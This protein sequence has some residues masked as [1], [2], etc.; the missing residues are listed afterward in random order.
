M[1]IGKVMLLGVGFGDFDFFMLKVVKVL[2]VVDVLLFDDF[3]VFGIV[4]F[5]LQ[6]CVICVGKCGGC[7]FMLQVFIEKL[8]CCYVLCGVYVVCVK[9]GDVL[10]FGC[11]GEEFVM[12]CVVVI[13]VEIVNGILLGFVVVVSFGILFMYCEYCQGVM[14]V[15]VYCQDYGEFDWVWF[16][17]IGIMFVIYMGMSCVDSIVVG[18]F[19]VFF[20]LMLVVVV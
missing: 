7:C 17:V 1:M 9:G 2:V 18:L 14:F 13:L 15:I 19:V 8:M 20:V 5:V 4:E 3:V 12:L 11:V 16:V 6:V 10:L